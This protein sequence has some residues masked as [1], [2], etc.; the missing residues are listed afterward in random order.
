[1]DV[2]EKILANPSI[3]SLKKKKSKSLIENDQNSQNKVQEDKS[4]K[5]DKQKN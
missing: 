5:K 2:K 3:N 4:I 1:M